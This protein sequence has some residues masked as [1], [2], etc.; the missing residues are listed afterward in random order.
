MAKYDET[1]DTHPSNFW[2]RAQLLED[3]YYEHGIVSWK[4]K[5]GEVNRN[6]PVY[7]WAC[8]ELRPLAKF[9]K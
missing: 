8:Q 7:C 5:C 4:C 6:A 3:E 2:K 9:S 1:K